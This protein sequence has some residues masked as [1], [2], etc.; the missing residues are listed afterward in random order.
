MLCDFG[1]KRLDVWKIELK[2]AKNGILF[3]FFFT[4]ES[5]D[6]QTSVVYQ[7][8]EDSKVYINNNNLL[9]KYFYLKHILVVFNEFLFYFSSVLVDPK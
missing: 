5:H 4:Y 3:T 8:V 2:M 6:S 7:I 9:I 1:H